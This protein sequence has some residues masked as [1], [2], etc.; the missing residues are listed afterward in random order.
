MHSFKSGGAASIAVAAGC[1]TTFALGTASGLLVTYPET[2]VSL[3]DSKE[4]EA[5]A[6]GVLADGADM[7]GSECW[8][9][10]CAAQL[11][12]VLNWETSSLYMKGAS[13]YEAKRFCTI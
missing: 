2:M 4:D 5:L 13:D 3:S 9:P 1:G 8:T 6:Y 12:R 11:N 10:R 7:G